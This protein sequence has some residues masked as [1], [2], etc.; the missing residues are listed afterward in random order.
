MIQDAGIEPDARGSKNRR[1]WDFELLTRALAR[2]EEQAGGQPRGPRSDPL[3]SFGSLDRNS[4]I[5]L[6]Q[7]I[8]D[9]LRSAI[10]RRELPLDEYLPSEAALS[11]H[12]LVARSTVRRAID[13]LVRERRLVPDGHRV[14]VD[15]RG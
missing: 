14:R 7:Q 3:A 12:Y 4:G 2:Y 5:A 10:D 1:Y 6:Y 13:L 11:Y 8:A 9:Q 15:G